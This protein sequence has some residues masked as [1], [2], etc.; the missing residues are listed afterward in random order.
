MLHSQQCAEKV[1]KALLLLQGKTL[2]RTHLL[3]NLLNLLH[4]NPFAA[5]LDIQ[6]LDRFCIPTRYPDALPGSLPEGLPNHEDA[7]E[8]LAVA[9]QVLRAVVA[10]TQ[11]QDGEEE[12]R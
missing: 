7:T 12:A 5:S 1:I 8:A 4:P 10:L 2:A 9:R 11:R 6:L 3:G